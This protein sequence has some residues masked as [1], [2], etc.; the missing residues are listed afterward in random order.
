MYTSFK[1]SDIFS[2]IIQYNVHL[3]HLFTDNNIVVVEFLISIKFRD[4]SGHFRFDR[5][6]IVDFHSAFF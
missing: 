4:A 6:H 5:F 2:G 1:N 3:S